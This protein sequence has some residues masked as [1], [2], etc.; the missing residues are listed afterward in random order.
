MWHARFAAETWLTIRHARA[1]MIAE[2]SAIH[3]EFQRAALS[4]AILKGFSLWPASVPRP[5]L[6][7]QLDIDF[8]VTQDSAREARRILEGRGYQPARHQRA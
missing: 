7:S 4:Y 2:L 3:R 6:R 5:E 8:L 1:A